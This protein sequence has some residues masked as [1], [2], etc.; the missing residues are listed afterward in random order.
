MKL[1]RRRALSLIGVA[2]A[3]TPGLAD[4]QPSPA[5]V[6]FQH[7][8][9]SGDPSATGVIL[10]TRVSTPNSQAA[11]R[12]DWEV[13]EG[14]DF[15][16]IVARGRTSTNAGRDFTVK[17][18]A[19]GL[20]PGRDYVY[21]FS[22]GGVTSPVGR[23]RTLPTGPT[24][25]VVLAVV[26]CALYPGGYFSAYDHLARSERVDAVVELGDYIYEYGAK[27]S[28]YGVSIGRTLNRLP[29]PAHDIVTLA[30][31]RT[32]YA[33]YRRDPDLQAA[34][35]RAPW[36]CVWD[37]HEV[38]NDTWMS[39]AEN[40]DP[41]TEG[42][43]ADRKRVALQAYFE[44]LP[45]REP[46]PGQAS[47]A[48]WRSFQFGDLASLMMLES[49]LAARSRQLEFEVP[50]DIPMAVYQGRG[51]TRRKVSD[52]KVIAR[53]LAE[54]KAGRTPAAPYV[55]G[56]DVE[57]VNAFVDDPSRQMLG[58]AQEAWL[59]GELAASVRA[60]RPWQI[61]GNQVVMA[62]MRNPDVAAAIGP[63]RLAKLID[64]RP[65]A[66]QA[67]LKR[68]ADLFSYP[69]P[70]DLDG[71]NGYPAARE[72]LYDT[73][74]S[75]KG[76]NTIVVSGDSHAFWTNQLSDSQGV[77]IAAELGSSAITSPSFG[78]ATGFQ[79]GKV[80]SDQNPEVVFNDQMAKGYIRL[81]LTRD[82][83]VGEMIGVDHLHKP[84]QSSTVA[85]WRL[86]PTE[87]VGVAAWEKLG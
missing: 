71:W 21:R 57:A 69:L 58:P 32:R 81:T 20:K 64:G 3:V 75:A 35:A 12:V 2:G 7:G 79:I 84:Y 19:S 25:Q 29:Q 87:G 47:E 39:G 4:A 1:N 33:Q 78:D 24:E 44:W 52:P 38:C 43:F 72:R 40:H 17:V 5:G 70:F 77:R 36:I 26:T 74:R 8:V 59:A 48:I 53:V 54:A 11:T 76:G 60:G 68:M 34:H 41:K 6:S 85:T 28:D 50:G 15:S 16:R 23:T 61:L 55:V 65:P 49:R 82:A 62:K 45:I 31:Y 14:A 63:E 51:A 46:K 22:S 42:A 10:W 27:E 37:D 83:A 73:I 9:A 18:D 86:R 67:R 80:F 30:D 56:P 13:G 66:G